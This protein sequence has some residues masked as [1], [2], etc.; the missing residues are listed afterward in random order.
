MSHPT[1]DPN[2]FSTRVTPEIWKK[3]Q[4][5]DHPF[6]NRALQGFPPASTFKIVT[7]TAGMESGKFSPDKD[8][9]RQHLCK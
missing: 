7:A 1:F 3:L 5:E 6:V 8:F 2:I 4:G 9:C